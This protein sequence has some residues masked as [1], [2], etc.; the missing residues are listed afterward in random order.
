MNTM[1]IA[2]EVMKHAKANYSHGGWDI[3]VECYSLQELAERIE[4]ATSSAD[5]IRKLGKELARRVE[6]ERDIQAEIF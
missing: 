5:A 2:E 3:I 4:G 6:Y 1:T